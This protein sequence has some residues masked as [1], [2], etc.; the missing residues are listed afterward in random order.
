[1]EILALTPRLKFKG[2]TRAPRIETHIANWNE[3]FE[4]IIVNFKKIDR[5]ILVI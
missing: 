4:K 3:R 1:M 2:F 5:L